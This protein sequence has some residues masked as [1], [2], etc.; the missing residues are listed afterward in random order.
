MLGKGLLVAR[1]PLAMMCSVSAG[2]WFW[3][4]LAVR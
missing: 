1:L 2:L 4:E 3:W